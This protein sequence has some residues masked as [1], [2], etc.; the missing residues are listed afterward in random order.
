MSEPP[1]RFYFVER[2]PRPRDSFDYDKLDARFA[3]LEERVDTI[4]D[5][6]EKVI[7][8]RVY[9][10]RGDLDR[11]EE[12]YRKSLA[13]EE[14]LGRKEGM[15]NDFGNLGSLYSTRGDLDRAESMYR[16]SLELFQQIGATPQVEQVRAMLSEIRK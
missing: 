11:A 8:N 14:A 9:S 16:R 15:A 1:R 7:L 12:M 5:D 2:P 6:V 3:K 13:I 10:I 4:K